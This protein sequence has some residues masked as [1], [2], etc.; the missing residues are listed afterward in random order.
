MARDGWWQG[1]LRHVLEE[2]S[3]L[4]LRFD[5][6]DDH[7]H[8][9]YL[10]VHLAMSD[11]YSVYAASS[12]PERFV[13]RHWSFLSETCADTRPSHVLR[14]SGGVYSWE[15]WC[16]N[17]QYVGESCSFL[18]RRGQL[19]TSVRHAPKQ[20]VHRVM[21]RLGL[22]RFVMMPVVV[23]LREGCRKEFESGYILAMQPQ[24]N[25]RRDPPK[26]VPVQGMRVRT[27]P[28]LHMRQ[29][30]PKQQEFAQHRFTRYVLTGVA[31]SA[32]LDEVLFEAE[33]RGLRACDVHVLR[34][35][36]ALCTARLPSQHFAHSLV[37]VP[38][39][40][41]WSPPLPLLDAV[42]QYA[43]HKADVLRFHCIVEGVVAP[44]VKA[45]LVRLLRDPRV[46]HELR[47]APM[48]VWLTMYRSA[49]AF[50]RDASVH[51]ARLLIT[52]GFRKA[53]G[54]R[55]DQ[56]PVVKVGYSEC[57][58][59][60][61]LRAWVARRIALLPV[62]PL[63]QQWFRS[64]TRIVMSRPA[65]IQDLLCRHR[66]EA[67]RHDP[68]TQ[69]QCVCHLYPA[70]C[71]VDGHVCCNG[72]VLMHHVF[73]G[74]LWL[75]GNIKNP[76]VL[77]PAAAVGRLAHGLRLFTESFLKQ[78]DPAL[79]LPDCG[80]IDC[81]DRV[82]ISV[83][84]VDDWC[85]HK[86][87]LSQLMCRF[88]AQPQRF[89]PALL[90]LLALYTGPG[91]PRSWA[92]PNS[93]VCSIQ[94]CCP[95]VTTHYFANPL[96][97]MGGAES[98]C[99]YHASDKLFGS[100]GDV[101]FCAWE[102]SGICTPAWDSRTL[103]RCLARAV[104]A[105]SRRSQP[106]RLFCV[107]PPWFQ[108]GSSYAG[109]Q[110]VLQCTHRVELSHAM[111]GV[112][113]AWAPPAWYGGFSVWLVQN[114]AA[115]A[116]GTE[117]GPLISYATEM[118]GSF[119]YCAAWACRGRDKWVYGSPLVTFQRD[120]SSG[121]VSTI[122][123]LLQLSAVAEALGCMPM[124]R[125]YVLAEEVLRV[126]RQLPGLVCAPLDRNPGMLHAQCCH[127]WHA[128]YHKLFVEDPHYS[129][130][131]QPVDEVLAAMRQEYES[132]PHRFTSIAQWDP[133]GRL[134]VAYMLKKFKDP[135]KK[136]R[137]IT[138]CHQVPCKRMYDA[139]G[140]C[141]GVVV[142]RATG[143]DHFD[144]ST[145]DALARNLEGLDVDR[146]RHVL[147]SFDVKNMY[148]ELQHA[149][150]DDD[151]HDFLM[152]VLPRF[153]S[154]R[155]YVLVHERR[156]AYVGKPPERKH[157]R[158]V[159]WHQL[160]PA[161][162]FEV[163]HAFFYAGSTLLQQR[164]GIGQGGKLSP[165]V[166]RIVCMMREIRLMAL[167]RRVLRLWVGNRF[168]D[169]CL[170]LTHQRDAAF[171]ATYQQCCY[172]DG[173]ELESDDPPGPA[174]RIL[175][176]AVELH[177]HGISVVQWNKNTE[178]ILATGCQK[179]LRFYHYTNRAVSKQLKYAVLAGMVS[180]YVRN[181]G[182]HSYGLL[183]QPLWVLLLEFRSVGYPWRSLYRALKGIRVGRLP[184]HV[185]SRP[186]FELM[187]QQLLLA[188]ESE[189]SAASCSDSDVSF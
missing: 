34:G 171:L 140:R 156:G 88:T 161:V 69:Y 131:P 141:L 87:V 108:P 54:F 138:P 9:A 2:F 37:S 149:V 188:V 120:A 155:F 185:E 173:M 170:I 68:H 168:V 3:A 163:H 92:V 62:S 111:R 1:L 6:L 27:V 91:T 180:R 121:A 39:A 169:D 135:A 106:R 38:F 77:D 133:G 146:V 139:V 43:A 174:V 65:A 157:V 105:V 129:H 90:H 114:R 84:G 23:C 181:T 167:Y 60:V 20:V 16:L 186:A 132:S 159:R 107:C 40:Q 145:T 11:V 64:R 151:V 74:E 85:L 86:P 71:K 160:H 125:A 158:V 134:G 175:E 162:M 8:G 122:M 93:L 127:T 147:A 153:K 172:A 104:R 51:R 49:H 183:W 46:C 75:A 81:G 128:E 61:A 66:Q 53:F 178:H 79:Q 42:V 82:L 182:V 7:A 41:G 100:S 137:P 184:V 150:I 164:N 47:L 59:M 126:K 101:W 83:G 102:R 32:L 31:S 18:Q 52:A 67:K 55:L 35:P 44:E 28:R 95:D 136:A 70:A 19:V 22:H 99:S 26:W 25:V 154:H 17:Q 36:H 189:M 177:E 24:L 33:A 78:V 96:A 76:V 115:A 45:M 14:T 94:A 113:A 152:L 110:C 72:A 98:Y 187:W 176:S 15:S 103:H 116:S 130:V 4:L 118:R 179:I 48:D 73:P 166:A 123:Q 30:K 119:Q 97:V 10:D 124:P 5:S 144:I 143:F 80:F 13:R 142:A 148:T 63:M 165:W 58:D 112:C 12:P 50:R 89:R 57:I 21:R 56:R 117:W 29:R 109:L